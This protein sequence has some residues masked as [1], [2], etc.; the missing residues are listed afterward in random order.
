MTTRRRPTQESSSSS[1][2][3]TSP[4]PPTHPTR[5]SPDLSTED[6]PG[7]T[8]LDTFRFI[9]GLVLLSATL[10]YFV[11]NTSLTWTY[12]PRWTR[13]GVVRAW[14]RGPLHLHP[15]QLSLYNGTDAS[16]PIYV[17]LNSTIYDVSAT[18]HMYGPGGSYHTLAGRDG[19]R[20]FVTG[21]FGV[22]D[23]VADLRGAERAFLPVDDV[24]TPEDGEGAGAREGIKETGRERKLRRERE[25]REAKAMV[26]DAVEGWERF[27]GGKYPVVGRVVREEGDG[28]GDGKERG[29]CEAA[30]RKRPKK[31]EKMGKK[32]RGRPV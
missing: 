30:E 13:G 10:S 18:P 9:A 31:G 8:L 1:S 16:L 24:G 15:T 14:L 6:N 23:V 29:L 4:S 20:A 25:R 5:P 19:A 17:A 27:L 22:E 2:S 7:L 21:C 3:E 28:E 32:E 26:K 11:T 12:R